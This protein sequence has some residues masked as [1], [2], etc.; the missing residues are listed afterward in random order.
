[1]KATDRQTAGSWHET[2]RHGFRDAWA[3]RHPICVPGMA[4]VVEATD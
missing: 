3:C 2:D 4:N 1:M